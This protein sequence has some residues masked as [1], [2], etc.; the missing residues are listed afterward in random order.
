M[1]KKISITF[2]CFFKKFPHAIEIKSLPISERI[3]SKKNRQL[4]KLKLIFSKKEIATII[5]G[6]GTYNKIRK[7]KFY[8]KNKIYYYNDMVETKLLSFNRKNK[9]KNIIHLKNI[10]PLS[11]SINEFIRRHKNNRKEEIKL[12]L[13]IQRIVDQSLRSLKRGEQSTIL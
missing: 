10:A 7:G 5:V 9:S 11:S 12:G 1:K 13:N 2:I 4:I 6:N 3:K 8:S